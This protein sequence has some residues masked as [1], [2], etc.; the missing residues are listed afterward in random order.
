[1]KVFCGAALLVA[2][3][4]CNDWLKEEEPGKSTP[5]D[6]FALGKAAIRAVNAAYT[7]LAWEFNS[8]YFSEWFIGDIA[9]DDALKGG[10][11][12]SDMA[13]AYDIENFK[14]NANNSL[15]RDFYRAQFQGIQ[16]CNLAM[17]EVEA[18]EPDADMTAERKTCLMGEAY[19]MRA[20]YYFRLVRIFGGVPYVDKVIDSSKDWKQPRATA[21]EIY[22]HIID[23]LKLAEQMLWNKSKYADADLGRATKGAAQAMLLKLI[24]ICTTITMH[25]NGVRNSLKSRRTNTAFAR[26]TQTTSLSPERT[27]LNRCS[28]S[29]IW[30]I[31]RATTAK[32]S[33]SPA[34]RSPQSSLVAVRLRSAEMQAGASTIRRR[35]STMSLSRAT[36]AAKPLS[37]SLLTQRWKPIP[38]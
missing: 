33:A 12:L 8:T 11:N 36:H 31:L 4:S 24:S 2:A 7:P 17:Q 32:V 26:T 13:D 18:I 37:A 38:T 6:Y 15:L 23:D 34:V 22:N 35:T 3:T 19:Y 10:Q 27:V 20:Y 25:T 21:E 28:K 5:E 16:R 29:S 9:S 1:M 30:Q 14:T